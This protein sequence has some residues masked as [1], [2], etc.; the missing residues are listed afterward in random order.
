MSCPDSFE[1]GQTY[2]NLW[3]Y[4]SIE[5]KAYGTYTAHAEDVLPVLHIMEQLLFSVRFIMV[6]K[7]LG[8]WFCLSLS[9]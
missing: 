4:S 6:I 9:Y 1:Q 5:N 7:S 3:V 8:I 2:V